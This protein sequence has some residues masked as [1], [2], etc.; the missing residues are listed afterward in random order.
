MKC[1]TNWRSWSK[2]PFPALI[3]NGEW[4]SWKESHTLCAHTS[5]AGLAL[6][7]CSTLQ[8]ALLVMGRSYSTSMQHRTHRTL[9]TL[10]TSFT[11]QKAGIPTI[12]TPPFP[13]MMFIIVCYVFCNI[14]KHSSWLQ[15]PKAD[16]GPFRARKFQLPNREGSKHAPLLWTTNTTK[17]TKENSTAAYFLCNPQMRKQHFPE[18]QA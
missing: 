14:F 13:S 10:S 7:R 4:Q 6:P 11:Q 12:T 18:G 16:P 17:R 9:S 15:Q 1:S 8:Q 5:A 3:T 2:A